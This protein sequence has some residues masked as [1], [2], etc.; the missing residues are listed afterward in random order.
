[1][2]M[3]RKEFKMSDEQLKGLYE[4]CKPVPYMVFGGIP[5]M[6][7]QEHANRYWQ[8]LADEMGFI[9]DTAKPISGKGNEYF[10]AEVKEG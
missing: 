6:S 2:K 8:K 7:A 9:W 10:S 4:A 5:P 1:M 3:E